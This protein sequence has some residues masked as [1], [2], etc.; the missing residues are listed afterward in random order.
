MCKRVS[1]WVAAVVCTAAATVSVQG[2]ER[3]N[4]PNRVFEVQSVQHDVSGRLDQMVGVHVPPKQRPLLST[5]EPVPATNTQPDPVLQTSTA[6]SQLSGSPGFPGVG[7]GFESYLVQVAP[8]DPNLAVSSHYIVQW[9]NTSL[10]VFDRTQGNAPVLLEAGNTI[11]SGVGGPCET[12]NDGDPIVQYDRADDRWVFTQLANTSGPTY[13]Q[14]FA[15]STSNDPRG[16]YNRYAW[17]FSSLNDYPKLG[18]WSDGFYGSYNMFL[19]FAGTYFFQGAMVCGY[20]KNAMI[21]GAASVTAQCSQLSASY[22]SL[23]PADIDGATPPPTGA[24]GLF[25]NYGSNSLN[26]WQLH[27][28]FTNVNNATLTGPINIPVAAFSAACNGGTCIPQP[29]TTQQLDSLADRLMYRL[30]YRNFGDHDALVVNHSVTAGTSTGIRWYEIRNATTASPSVYQ[31]GTFAPD[32]N[33][34]WMGSTAMDK[35]GD[36]AVGYS[37]SNG[38]SVFPSIAYSGRQASDPLGTMQAETIMLGGTGSQTTGLSR[39][40]DYTALRIDPADDCTFWYTNQYLQSS[41]TFN[42]ST[43]IA[44]FSFP[45]CASTAPDFTLTAT[46][47]SQTVTQGNQTTYSV[48]YSALNGYSGSVTLS[49]S[50]PTGISA[51]FSPNPITAPGMVSTM[52]VSTSSNVTG[53][54]TLTITGTDSSAS[55][56]HSTS[57]QLVVNPTLVS[58]SLNPTSV[59]AGSSSTGTVTL[60]GAVPVSETVTLSS[61]NVQ[62]ATVPSQVTL[63]AGASYVTFPVTTYSVQASTTVTIT[64][65]YGSQTLQTTL[66]VNPAPTPSFTLTASPTS[67]TIA[68]GSR[69]S[70][71]ITINPVNGFSSSVTFSASGQP[72]YTSVKFSPNPSTSSTKM[73][74]SVGNRAHSGTYSITVNGSS[75]NLATSTSV[76]LTIP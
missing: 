11:W 35:L 9:V 15:V 49:A 33:Y 28:D 24:P 22:G 36:M 23:L 39:W 48:S 20:D 66:T 65:T 44:S 63:S 40:G 25:V 1:V 30:A 5:S 6:P 26:L 13:Y 4:P 7:N 43:W 61:S 29:Q 75:G 12:T 72:A 57:A 74:I 76:S 73:T 47:S 17:T 8:P 60:S 41:G 54:D 10:A 42:W 58:L 37:V 16:P 45:G 19:P 46:P 14:C 55:L 38:S 59:S 21:Q 69:S 51:S 27:V 32:G 2:Q 62:V 68:R 18:V 52:T 64:A 70:S 53:N 67:L 50:T 56:T 71:T 3:G 31:Q 34:R